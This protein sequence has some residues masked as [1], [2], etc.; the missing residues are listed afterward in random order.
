MLFAE[1]SEQPSGADGTDGGLEPE[2]EKDPRIDGRR[3][4]IAGH[5]PNLIKENGKIE[6]LDE[7]PEIANGMIRRQGLIN[8]I[9]SELALKAICVE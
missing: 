3:A 8:G 2:R 5:G 7:L 6:R 1:Q 9:V 4:G